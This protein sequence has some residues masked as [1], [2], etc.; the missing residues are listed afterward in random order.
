MNTESAHN[1]VK[2]ALPKI[3]KAWLLGLLLGLVCHLVPP[4]YH[5]ACK[6]IVSACTP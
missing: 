1:R 6:A 5:E 4:E 3:K 2:K